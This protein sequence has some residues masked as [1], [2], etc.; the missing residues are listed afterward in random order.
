MRMEQFKPAMMK[1]CEPKVQV[2]SKEIKKPVFEKT[3]KIKV[4][5]KFAQNNIRLNLIPQKIVK[6][7]TTEA[8]A[9][10]TAAFKQVAKERQFVVQ[11]H[12]VKV[13]K[14][15]KTYSF[16]LL[17]TDVIRNISMFKADPKV[18]KEQIEVL[19]QGDY[20]KRDENNR[21]TLIYLP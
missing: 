14:S 7:K 8:T 11:A 6:K 3:E 16:Q 4:N 21:A 10:E 15:Q 18:V 13:M 5:P 12:I 9:E 2:L 1:L 17:L 20:M 19:I